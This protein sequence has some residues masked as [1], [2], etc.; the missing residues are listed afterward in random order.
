MA[1]CK[2][3]DGY[4]ATSLEDA[5]NHSM[6][7]TLL[8]PTKSGNRST[9]KTACIHDYI[10]TAVCKRVFE[11][12]GLQIEARTQVNPEGEYNVTND[13]DEHHNCD[14]AFFPLDHEHLIHDI[15]LKWFLRSYQKNAA[16]YIKNMLGETCQI[17]WAEGRPDVS[18][19][20]LAM[21]HMPNIA[22]GKISGWDIV[23]W[24]EYPAMIQKHYGDSSVPDS[25]FVGIFEHSVDPRE[26]EYR[27]YGDYQM[28]YAASGCKLALG[29]KTH[30]VG[31]FH[32]N[33]F[34]QFVEDVADMIYVKMGQLD[35]HEAA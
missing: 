29:K 17:H 26:C 22:K 14:I 9:K 1:K 7:A 34:E 4:K 25:I 31:H 15:E 2:N 28:G 11:K 18:Q 5:A 13:I 21:D 10:G 33:D 6:E 3:Y 30:S 32:L 12:Y 8:D 16:N 20:I 19:I 23:D 35:E 27:T 24:T